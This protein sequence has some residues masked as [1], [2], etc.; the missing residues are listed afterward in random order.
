MPLIVNGPRTPLLGQSHLNCVSSQFDVFSS[1][2]YFSRIL[3]LVITDTLVFPETTTHL[4]NCPGLV[5]EHLIPFD[6][7]SK[8]KFKY[9]YFSGGEGFRG[10]WFNVS[11]IAFSRP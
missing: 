6:G 11:L 1:L 9:L 3:L 5:T 10:L 2:I 7:H 4:P 8:Y